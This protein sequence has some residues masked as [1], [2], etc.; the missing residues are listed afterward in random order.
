MKK[1][2]KSLRLADLDWERLQRVLDVLEDPKNTKCDNSSA[3]KSSPQANVF[4]DAFAEFRNQYPQ[5]DSE[6]NDDVWLFWEQL[7]F[8]KCEPDYLVLSGAGMMSQDL[9]YMQ[10]P[11]LVHHY[12]VVRRTNRSDHKLFDV[13]QFLRDE[14]PGRD[15]FLYMN[16]L[17]G[18]SV[19]F[20]KYL[21]KDATLDAATIPFKLD[22]IRRIIA[23]F[24]TEFLAAYGPGL[25]SQF[26]V[27][28]K[29][30]S[31]KLVSFMKED[32]DIE[33]GKHAMVLI[34]YRR[35]SDAGE[36]VFLLQNSWREC[37]FIEVSERYLAQTGAKIIFIAD[38]EYPEG[39]KP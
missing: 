22:K 2:Q 24:I 1:R 35:D 12:S 4:K 23:E 32:D 34:G 25:V 6:K 17:G 30:V 18:S 15:F 26:K 11:A 10:A 36:L 9:C 8:A 38:D 19:E 28:Q 14:C 20:L 5:W 21:A 7:P 3:E 13:K 37:Y 27:T 31:R 29:F 39:K 16:G 33:V